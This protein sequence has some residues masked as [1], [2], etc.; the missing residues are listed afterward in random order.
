MLALI[1]ATTKT[2][3]SF[4]HC[5]H[6]SPAIHPPPKLLTQDVHVRPLRPHD[7]HITAKRHKEVSHSD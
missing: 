3:D 2:A 7:N 6:V 4:A 5:L 1:F